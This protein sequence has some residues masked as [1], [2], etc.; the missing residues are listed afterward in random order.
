MRKSLFLLFFFCSLTIIN[1]QNN[2]KSGYLITN[3]NDTI[4]G[5]INLRTNKMNAKVCEFKQTEAD[6]SKVYYPGDIAGYRF[7]DEGRFYITKDIEIDSI[8]RTVFIEYLLQGTMNLYF[9]SDNLDYYFFEDEK[10][11]QTYITNKPGD[12]RTDR[13]DVKYKGIM[14][15]LFKDTDLV[16]QEAYKTPFNRESIKKLTKKYHEEMCTSG[17]Q[18]I[19]FEAKKEKNI[20]DVKYSLYVGIGFQSYSFVDTKLNIINP[21]KYVSPAIGVQASFYLP[22]SSDS[23]SLLVDIALS[24]IKA[25]DEK[26]YKS[27]EGYTTKM[28]FNFDALNCVGRLGLKYTY[29]KGK[30]R[31]TIEGGATLSSLFSKSSTY[32]YETTVQVTP[33]EKDNYILPETSFLGY[34]GAVGL[35]MSVKQKQSV[36]ARVVYD[37]AKRNGDQL[38][39]VQ[40]RFGYTF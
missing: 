16:A 11:K 10:G 5:L 19:E 6:N 2:Y 40:L 14:F 37:N 29:P 7:T 9:Y 35:D 39:T 15:Y 24:S 23:F 34:Y 20:I 13:G 30:Y 8:L 3:E 1:A 4:R 33:F 26:N 28:K 32:Y 12:K 36:F 21:F 38:K 25:D 18:C 17:E 31:P 22:Q 27:N